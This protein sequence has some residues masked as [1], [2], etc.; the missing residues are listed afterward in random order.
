LPYEF[1]EDTAA[2]QDVKVDKAG[3]DLA[4][5]AQRGKGRAVGA[6]GGRKTDEFAIAG[7]EAASALKGAG[8]QFE[9]YS[10]TRVTGV[11]VVACVRRTAAS[12]SRHSPLISAA[13]RRWRRRPS[14]SK[15]ADRCPIRPDRQRGNRR[16]GDR[17]RSGAHPARPAAR[18]PRAQSPRASCASAT[19][20]PP[21]STPWSATRRAAMHTATHLLHA[22]LRRCAWRP[23]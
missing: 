22:A 13:T 3:Y 19:L 14:T 23:P 6:F 5:E 2:T 17:R 11:P 21:K 10:T 9:G 7:D 12:R 4:M 8:D 20:S 18:A 15:Q 16:V 1:I